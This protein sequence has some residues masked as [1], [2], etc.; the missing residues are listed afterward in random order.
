MELKIGQRTVGKYNPDTKQ[1]Y[2]V[3]EKSK[4]LFNKDKSWGISTQVLKDLEKVG[5]EKIVIFETEEQEYYVTP[6]TV[7]MEKSWEHAFEDHDL[8]RFLRVK[9]FDIYDKERNLKEKSE[10][11]GQITFHLPTKQWTIV[12]R[13]KEGYNKMVRVE[14]ESEKEYYLKQEKAVISET[15]SL[16]TV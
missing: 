1:F 11:T 16:S 3:V 9:H 6:F 12:Y 14:S 4:H 10:A 13:D 7:F 15:K 5:C 8:Q 2:K